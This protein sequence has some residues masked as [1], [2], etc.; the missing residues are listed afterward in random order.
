MTVP[1]IGVTLGD[2]AGI[3]PEIVL[4]ALSGPPGPLEAAYVL[5]GDPRIIASTGDDLGLRLATVP[6]KPRDRGEKGVFVEPVLAPPGAGGRGKATANNGA[7]SFRFFESA[8]HAARDGLLDAVVT[9]PIS[10]AA[11]KLAGIPWRGH[12]EYLERDHPGAVM[13]FWSESLRVALLSH[14]LPLREALGRIR[15]SDLIEFLRNLHRGLAKAPGGPFEILV[16][17]LNPHAGEGGALGREEEEVI[18]PA[19]EEAVREGIPATGPFPPDTVFLRSRG[20]PNSIVAALYHDQGLIGFKLEAFESG[21]N[22]TLG[23]PFARTSPDHGT[24]FD[25]AGLGQADARSMREALRLA[26]V[27]SASAS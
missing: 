8:V 3:G 23:L 15:R 7:A 5:F 25:I 21:V 1:R 18:R 10:K 26:G 24:A 14:H 2:P 19:V 4:K 22:V 9:A 12:T 13:S 11:W 16:A 6:W 20:R 27:F 17:G